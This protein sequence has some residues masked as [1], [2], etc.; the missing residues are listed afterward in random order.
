MNTPTPMM[1][2]WQECKE[3]VPGTILFFRLGD[4][5]EAFHDDALLISK[6][7][8]LTLTKRQ[9]IPMA[10]VPF[11]MGDQYIDKLVAKGHKVA[12]AEQLE[13]PKQVK[14]IVKRDIVRIVTP[15]TVIN[16]ELLLDKSDNYFACLV[17]VNH[18]FGLAYIDI[19]TSK[20]RVV[21]FE[22]SKLLLDE[23]LRLSPKELLLSAKWKEK[24]KELIKE[25]KDLVDLSLNFKEEWAFEH[26]HCLQFLLNHFKVA[27]LDGFGLQ[28]KI[29]AINAAGSLLSY[30]KE[31]LALPLGHIQT[32]Q[33]DSL[34]CYLS[35]DRT[36]QKNLELT[37]S[38]FNLLDKTSTP[39]GGRL[40]KEWILHPLLDPLLIQ[41]RQQ[42]IQLFFSHPE[43]AAS[44][45]SYLRSI[46]D[47]ERLIMRIETGFASPRDIAGLSLSLQ[48][49]P[50]IATL[51]QGHEEK[52]LKED[53][54]L[55][56]GT[57]EITRII[58]QALVETPPFRIS[59]G[60]IFKKGYSAELDEL[61]AL[62]EDSH[63]W[64][65]R[66][67]VELRESTQIK[68]LK[69]GYT[70]A[71]GYYIE[72]S[73]GASEKIPSHFQR[74]Q[75]LVNNERYITEE[76]KEFEY[77]ILSA[78]DRIQSLEQDLFYELRKK[79]A[80]FA[81]RVRKIAGAIG[82]IDCL[83]ALA[84]VA[85]ARSYVRPCVDNSDRFEIDDGRHPVIEAAMVLEHFI[86]NSVF[87]GEN[88][89]RLALIT[90][91]NMAGKSTYLRQCALIAIMA[92]I[93]SFVPAKSAHMGIIDKVFCRIGAS[94]DLARGQST[95]MVEMTETANILN[96]A[97]SG[98]LIILDEIG[99]GTSTYDGISIA[100]AV[101]E[102]LLTT[103]G[104]TA[105]TLF[106]THYWEL[107]E[108][109][110]KIAGAS[111]FHV[112]VHEKEKNI[113][114][115]RKILP[116]S[117]N[118]SYGIHVAR[119]AGLPASVIHRAEERLLELEKTGVRIK[120]TPSK[121]KEQLEFL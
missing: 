73:R 107:T 67:Q 85:R 7:L 5:Y 117:A 20:F 63:S 68:S 62:K 47:L 110:K 121:K 30:L 55:L 35:L 11:H 83:C 43:L 50:N 78:E 21:E 82:R 29:A 36:T 66:F 65:A 45:S 89:P 69:V 46:R 116:G 101:A 88:H 111:N 60:N 97:T 31:D 91:P 16:S 39:M 108:L 58:D 8:D 42:A 12:I 81:S 61:R 44:L 106:A 80:V 1:A 22:D 84:I 113:I 115:L 9:E 59:D 114:F 17:Q 96:N 53:C 72:T 15:G 23:L 26:R 109:E 33:N 57:E 37:T 102:Y 38:L 100:W 112:A 75:T 6:E 118:K 98:S 93:G 120:S 119:I 32:I 28:T 77:K 25:I 71:F 74:K 70:K 92:Q 95:F 51:L 87:L 49:I 76:L 64:M 54:A 34:S 86:P 56:V 27:S 94:D 3:K 90:G 41:E 2:Q 103:P 52:L 99:R 10:G 14:G 40:L 48:Q 79:I 4:F 13:D 105:K 19:T 24:N 18:F 104:K